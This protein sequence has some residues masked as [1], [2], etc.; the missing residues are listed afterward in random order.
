MIACISMGA[1]ILSQ[2]HVFNA[3]CS[4]KVSD[5]HTSMM[6]AFRSKSARISDQKP[7]YKSTFMSG[8]YKSAWG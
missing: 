4:I 1:S 7:T 8:V 5:V 3:H 6:R 2:N